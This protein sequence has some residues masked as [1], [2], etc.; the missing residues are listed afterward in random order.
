MKVLKRIF[1][2]LTKNRFEI[3]TDKCKFLFTEI[4]YLRYLVTEKGINPTKNSIDAVTNFS[5][6]TDV[7]KLQSFLGLCSYFRKFFPNFAIISKPLYDL[8]KKNAIFNIKN[9]E[10]N[11]F[12]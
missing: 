4:E 2:L 11:A 8:L 5:L 7:Y 1:K 3:R 6:P 12:E 9:A 10:L